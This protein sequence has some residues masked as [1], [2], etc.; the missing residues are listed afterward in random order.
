VR[1]LAE[2][3]PAFSEPG[4][5]TVKIAPALAEQR[6][7]VFGKQPDPKALRAAAARLLEL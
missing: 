4:G 5:P 6:L 3:A 1:T 7:G 2:W